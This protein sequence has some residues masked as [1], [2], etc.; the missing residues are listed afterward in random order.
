MQVKNAVVV[1]ASGAIGYAFIELLRKQ[2]QIKTIYALARS[3]T[4]FSDTNIVK[5]YIDI[6][7]E[8]SIRKAAEQIEQPIDL[9]VVATGVLHAADMQP[10]KSLS[11]L[12]VKNFQQQFAINTVGPALVAKHF[13]PLL[14]SN[15]R[16]IFAALSARIGSIADNYLGGWY[17]YRCA[18]A[19][20]NMFIRTASIEIKRS[21]RQAI[22]VGLHPGTVDSELSKP[23]Q[24]RVPKDR[25]FSA[26]FAVSQLY[27]VILSLDE[28]SSGK[29][30]AYDG[31]QIDY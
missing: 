3:M 23:F 10:E 2:E 21:N 24:K 7:D 16:S 13:L 31:K 18:K 27:Q 26:D 11:Q 6:T 12:S 9:I 4:D 1:G 20:L 14:N 30:F 19:A 25:L 8:A 5:S 17:A 28:Q 15:S 22:I 29:V